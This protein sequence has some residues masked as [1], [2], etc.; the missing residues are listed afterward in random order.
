MRLTALSALLLSLVAAACSSS[1]GSSST[2]C[3]QDP[4]QCSSTQTCWPQSATAFACMNA[5]PGMLGSACED[6]PGTPTCG[7]GLFCLQTTM[8]PGTCLAYCS[9]SD[10]KHACTGGAVCAMGALGGLGGPEFNLCV[11]M[12][13]GDGGTGADGGGTTD[14]GGTADGGSDAPAGG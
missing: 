2:P 6:T 11:P 7:A 13:V 4:W 1:S 12:A 14:G 8:M 9:T 10:P 5:G 3:N